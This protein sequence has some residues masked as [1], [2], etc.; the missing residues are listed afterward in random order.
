MKELAISI[1]LRLKIFKNHSISWFSLSTPSNDGVTVTVR[2]L[3]VGSVVLKGTIKDMI[4]GG[5]ENELG[6][7]VRVRV[8]LCCVA[9]ELPRQQQV[10]GKQDN[11][12]RA[13][14]SNI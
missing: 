13:A 12:Q 4:T 11:Y 3:L 8:N 2:A 14:V 5:G 1:L 7:T 10:L 9:L 6:H